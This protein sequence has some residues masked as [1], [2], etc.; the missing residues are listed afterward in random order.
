MVAPIEALVL[1]GLA[2]ACAAFVVVAIAAFRKLFPAS[3]WSRDAMPA[4]YEA[5]PET[6]DL[7]RRAEE[8]A[9]GDR[10]YVSKSYSI[11]DDKGRVLVV[12]ST[13]RNPVRSEQR[14]WEGAFRR[15]NGRAPTK[16]EQREARKRGYTHPPTT[17]EETP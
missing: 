12:S 2:L 10:V 4:S 14:R 11:P 8:I 3:R 15:E 9:E 7:L 1:L 13:S 6:I 17:T 16:A 5:E